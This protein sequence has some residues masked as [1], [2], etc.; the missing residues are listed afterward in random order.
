MCCPLRPLCLVLSSSVN[1]YNSTLWLI[2]TF[3]I[4]AP[5]AF[6]LF[7]YFW[8]SS[9]FFFFDS[10][11]II[12]K[13]LLLS[14]G[15]LWNWKLILS[16]HLNSGSRVLASLCYMNQG[17]GLL[18]KLPCLSPIIACTRSAHL[19]QDKVSW[20]KKLFPGMKRFLPQRLHSRCKGHCSW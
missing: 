3:Y 13:Y 18:S 14:V 9:F 20:R 8:A 16:T 19:K 5:N 15:L 17:K 10:K 2:S 12:W 6:I 11:A 4:I 1:L 7:T